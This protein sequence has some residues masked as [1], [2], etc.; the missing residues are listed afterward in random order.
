MEIRYGTTRVVFLIGEYAIKIPCYH[1]WDKFLKGLLGNMCEAFNYSRAKEDD[2][3]IFCP[4]VFSCWGGWFLVMR[5][6]ERITMDEYIKYA[7]DTNF[8][9]NMEASF[10]C[11]TEKKPDSL[12]WYRGELRVIDYGSKVWADALDADIDE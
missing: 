2:D 9:E 7:I 12:G 11:Y 6:A 3:P 4:I 8:F 5:R 10:R 1:H